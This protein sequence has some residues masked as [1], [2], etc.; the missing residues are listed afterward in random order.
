MARCTSLYRKW[1]IPATIDWYA[2]V[3][4]KDGLEVQQV[5]HANLLRRPKRRDGAGYA[6]REPQVAEC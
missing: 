6:E 1:T 2:D 4:A 3:I 5:E